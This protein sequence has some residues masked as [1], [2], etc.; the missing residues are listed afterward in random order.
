MLLKGCEILLWTWHLESRGSRGGVCGKQIM[1]LS[2]SSCCRYCLQKKKEKNISQINAHGFV[3]RDKEMGAF[4]QPLSRLPCVHI[5]SS[6]DRSVRMFA[7]KDHTVLHQSFLIH[8][9]QFQRIN[10]SVITTAFRIQ[11]HIWPALLWKV[12]NATLPTIPW[13]FLYMY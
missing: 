4:W 12:Y 9:L 7:L 8:C 5:S 13:K 6:L 1:P 3:E 2:A 10:I 11:W